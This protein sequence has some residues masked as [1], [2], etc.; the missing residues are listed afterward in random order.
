MASV[1]RKE[2]RLSWDE[3]EGR[4]VKEMMNEKQRGKWIHSNKLETA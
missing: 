2:R 3:H 1:G 4:A